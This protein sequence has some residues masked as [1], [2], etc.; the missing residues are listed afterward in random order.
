MP[1]KVIIGK[2]GNQPFAL[3][4]PKVSRRHAELSVLDNGQLILVD[5]DSTNG[6]FI[7]NGQQFVRI[8][9]GKQ[10]PVKGDTMIQ[11]GPETRFHVRKLVP[12]LAVGQNAAPAKATQ[13]SGAPLKPAGDKQP[14]AKKCDIS[15]LRKISENYS[16]TKMEIQTK[17]GSINSMRSLT[18]IA[19]LAATVVGTILGEVFGDKIIGL[20]LGVVVAL[21]IIGTLITVINHKNKQLIRL[22]ND[23]EKNYALK[24]CCPECHYSFKNKL[25]ENV[26]AERRC[27]K[28]KTEFYEASH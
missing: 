1:R 5:T 6:T 10:Y 24:Y 18:L 22:Q 13:G 21:V 12:G 11:L 4:D 25:Y 2:E 17:Q 7:Y 15:H 28:C 23:N 27:P 19:S 9:P 14:Q 16:D 8:Q 3:H 20:V 26:L